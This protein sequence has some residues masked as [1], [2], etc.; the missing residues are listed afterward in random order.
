[1]R[2]NVQLR[3][4]EVACDLLCVRDSRWDH[5]WLRSFDENKSRAKIFH[6][7]AQGKCCCRVSITQS[8][9]MP[10]RKTEH[11]LQ[12]YA[13]EISSSST[14]LLLCN[15]SL[16][17]CVGETVSLILRELDSQILFQFR[18][19]L[20]RDRSC[21]IYKLQAI[22]AHFSYFFVYSTFFPAVH[23][24]SVIKIELFTNWF[25]SFEDSKRLVRVSNDKSI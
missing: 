12:V 10:A 2:I 23:N 22:F 11:E 8:R 25:S 15:F 18:S 14:R 16:W 3:A 24:R 13:C 19:A 1:M 21:L 4:K 6:K 5:R 20:S 7:R 9:S 17:L